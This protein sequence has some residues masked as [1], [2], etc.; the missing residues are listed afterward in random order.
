MMPSTFHQSNVEYSGH[1]PDTAIPYPST[2]DVV[3]TPPSLVLHWNHNEPPLEF[4]CFPAAR[5]QKGPGRLVCLRIG[6]EIL[7]PTS[8]PRGVLG[9]GVAAGTRPGGG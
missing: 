9:F 4:L 7:L 5:R 3:V 2:L 6:F 8:N 1:R